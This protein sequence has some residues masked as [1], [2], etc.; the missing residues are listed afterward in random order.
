MPNK[1]AYI[2]HVIK[3][4]N[5]IMV[6]SKSKT[7]FSNISYIP[8]KDS[9][10]DI[11]NIKISDWLE[12]LH[13]QGEKVRIDNNRREEEQLK[14]YAAEKLKRR[15]IS[16]ENVKDHTQSG[17]DAQARISAAKNEAD[18]QMVNDLVRKSNRRI[19]SI[20]SSF[21]WSFFP[22]TINV[23]E[24][25]VTFNFSQFLFSQSHSVEIK[26]ISNVYIES[27]MFFATLQVVSRTYIQNHIKIGH[28]NKKKAVLVQRI[29]EGLRTFSEH[30]I[31]TSNY[32][33]DELISKIGEFHTE[34]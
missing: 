21:P 25:R 19:I 3:D 20:S 30:N 2:I 9:A 27:S 23:E 1:C 15:K 5:I 10:N 14:T 6:K 32:E 16:I 17:I 22:D 4:Y 8:T 31:N 11:E 12:K 33:I 29:I 28:L 7:I 18:K 26:D 24:S 34:S 13:I